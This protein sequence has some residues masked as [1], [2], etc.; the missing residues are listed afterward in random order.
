M[1]SV[2]TTRGIKMTEKKNDGLVDKILNKDI[3][4]GCIFAAAAFAMFCV[5]AFN[6]LIVAALVRWVFFS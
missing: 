3:P 1:R 5:L 2:S 6:M 4:G